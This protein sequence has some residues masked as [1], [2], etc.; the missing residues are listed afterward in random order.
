MQIERFEVFAAKVKF[1]VF[2]VLAQCGVVVGY[3]V[4]E[5][6]AASIFRSSA[7]WFPAAT[8]DCATTHKSTTSKCK[9]FIEPKS[10]MWLHTSAI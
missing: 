3:K 10:L 7:A 4:S 2:W 8:L 1:V 9:T 5:D 6:R